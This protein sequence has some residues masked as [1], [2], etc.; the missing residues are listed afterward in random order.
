M[1]L[2][3]VVIFLLKKKVAIVKKANL[4]R[5]TLRH[6]SIGNIILNHQWRLKIQKLNNR[7]RPKQELITV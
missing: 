2:L 5:E 4:I 6:K 1:N 7:K 3:I